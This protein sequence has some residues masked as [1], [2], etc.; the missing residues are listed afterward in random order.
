MVA[1]NLPKHFVKCLSPLLKPHKI[2]QKLFRNF[3]CNDSGNVYATFLV[4]FQKIF[5]HGCGNIGWKICDRDL[6]ISRNFSEK[7]LQDFVQYFKY[8]NNKFAWNISIMVAANLAEHFVEC[9][10]PLSKPYTKYF[11]KVSETFRVMIVGMFTK[12]CL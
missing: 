7:F 1:L 8:L 2:F 12:H 3:P 4:I 11:R 6:N 10:C 5:L 9:L